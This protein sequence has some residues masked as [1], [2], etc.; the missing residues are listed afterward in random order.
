MSKQPVFPKYQLSGV[1]IDAATI[2]EANNYIVKR[3]QDTKS[4][5]CYVVKPYV[6]F[7]EQAADNPELAELLNDA[8]LCLPDGVALNWATYYLYAGQ[9]SIGR[10]VSTSL[11]I[12]F[13]PQR[14]YGVLPDRFGG[15]N[16]TWPLLEACQK[17]NLSV[18]LIG[19]PQ[20][21]TI[22]HTSEV[23]KQRLPE[24]QIVGTFKGRFDKAE[25]EELVSALKQAKPDL[26]LVGMGFPR[27]E[28]LMKELC[29]QLGHGVLVGEGG[30]FDYQSFGGQQI[31]APRLMQVIG[32][33]W[34]WRLVLEPHRWR[35]QLAIPRFMWRVFRQRKKLA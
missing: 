14:L 34:L 4:T 6:E 27:Q 24:L 35:R 9:P 12:I 19:S 17:Q 7:I 28:K 33:E 20:H 25:R 13:Q 30:T 22:E 1:E 16:T 26:I 23:V 2:E 32:L 29:K 8:E 18:F 3:A 10:F 31:R 15:I 11:Q 5:P 21:N